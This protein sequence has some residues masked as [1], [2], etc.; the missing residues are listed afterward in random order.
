MLLLLLTTPG[1]SSAQ[2]PRTHALL[3]GV[4]H[5]PNLSAR[6]QLDGPPNDVELARTFLTAPNVFA[7][8][9]SADI[10]VLAG[11]PA[12]PAARP[13]KRNIEAAFRRLADPAVTQPGDQVFILMAGHGSQQPAAA[14]DAD[15][16][17]GLDE[18]FLPADVQRWDG[19]IG[20]V[21]NAIT[22]NEI[23]S[24]VSAI[25][26]RGVFVWILFDSCHSATM[27]RG[28]AE[29]VR[30]VPASELGVPPAPARSRGIR[31]TAGQFVDG[32]DTA[33]GLVAFYA[34]QASETTPESLLPEDGGTRYHG[35]FTFHLFEI[36]AQAVEPLSYREL[37]G[38]L[39]ER[40]RSLARLAG[41]TPAVEGTA[42]DRRV[43][44]R[45]RLEERPP[46]ELTA[47]RD[48]GD[49]T[50]N[51]GQLH[52]LR[53]GA[54]L[55]VFPRAG[56]AGGDKPIGYVAVKTADVATAKVAPVAYGDAP[57]VASSALRPGLR[58]RVV[59]VGVE[60]PVLRVATENGTL[61]PL[62]DG[63]QERS[64]GVAAAGSAGSRPADW[65]LNERNG[66]VSLEFAA[67]ES[68][69]AVN[70]T[71]LPIG[72]SDDRDLPGRLVETLKR[73]ARANGLRRLSTDANLARSTE[74][75]LEAQ[76]TDNG[77]ASLLTGS[78][79]NLAVGQE[80]EFRIRNSGTRAVDLSV[81]FVG[82]DFS[83]SP[84]YPV[85][86]REA[87]TRLEPGQLVTVYQGTVSADTLGNEGIVV[88]GLP[89]K[90]PPVNL[91]VLAQGGA[92]TRGPEA[93]R[94]GATGLA[95]LVESAL[96]GTR[97]ISPNTLE[98]D[99]GYA[100]TMLSWNTVPMR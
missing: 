88:I 63:L 23:R 72:R 10:T 45:D 98:V 64:G 67:A 46:F 47:S 36:L 8:V 32:P 4:G 65:L 39:Y 71:A 11:W 33:Q 61:R 30:S 9:N 52:G 19:S 49:W 85:R 100:V 54:T 44:G 86:G 90:L 95:A 79:R 77:G 58:A 26:N 92:G 51:A 69:N 70:G 18:I 62:L 42:M 38:R 27:T 29:R 5:Y 21:P 80:V 59:T 76:V 40:Y 14:T 2:S 84:L 81:F 73:I 31:V 87:Q 97:A 89:P 37:A 41:P 3:V 66:S 78:T 96:S 17:D 28:G 93:R 25:T 91:T 22:D 35:L 60:Q 34:S 6:W 50:V 68:P 74:L 94:G 57:A 55:A 20:A 48:G 43:L 82:S 16:P 13:T 53:T 7:P 83:V 56:E 12:S 1:L 24:W 75:R 15:E 99:A